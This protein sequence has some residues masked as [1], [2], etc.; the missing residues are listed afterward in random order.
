MKNRILQIIN[1]SIVVKQK[2]KSLAAIIEKI[3]K[4]II[5]CYR[6]QNKVVLFGNGGS[7]ADAQHI[8]TELVCRFEKERESL[9]AVAL[10][11]NSSILTAVANDYKFDN[12]FSRQV[13]STV[14]KGDVVIALSTSGDSTNVV[15]AAKQSKKQGAVVV[16]FTGASGGKLKN[17]CD[18]ILKVPSTNTARIQEMHITI[19][20]II[21]KLIESELF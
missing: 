13:E 20:H 18:I 2:S 21:C 7:A 9:P 6:Q 8:A 15:N 17:V 4:E 3:V 11:T 19:G 14:Q 16:G 5:Q 1:D 10:T 12:I